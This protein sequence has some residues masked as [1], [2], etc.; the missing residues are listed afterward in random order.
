M[1][2]TVRMFLVVAVF[3]LVFCAFATTVFAEQVP[4]PISAPVEQEQASPDINKGLTMIAAALAV[5]IAGIGAGIAVGSGAP[6][7]IGALTEDP[8][9]FSKA[10]IFVALGEGIALYG[11][12]IAILIVFRA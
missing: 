1:K 7:A 3:S 12:L 6:A 10:L 8:K 5:G 2:K 9:S 4:V 11:L